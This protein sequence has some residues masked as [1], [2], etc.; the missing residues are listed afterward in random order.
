M[1][2]ARA[3]VLVAAA[4]ALVSGAG[5]ADPRTPPGL[6]GLP[7]PFLGTAL[8]GDGGMTV[9]VDS[10]GSVVD[11]RPGGPASAP[12]IAVSSR[13]QAAGTVPAGASLS[14][15]VGGPGPLE[16]LWRASRVRQ[17]RPR[18]GALSTAAEVGRLTVSITD[19]ARGPLFARLIRVR[20][21]PGRS[22]RAAVGPVPEDGAR[23]L[24]GSTG[25]RDPE[26]PPSVPAGPGPA[27]DARP[28]PP[29]HRHL[30]RG[31]G[32]IAGWLVCGAAPPAPGSG[33]DPRELVGTAAIAA[34]RWLGA[35]RPLG[36]A[37][38]GWARATYRRSLLVLRS[39][40]D[41]RTG[42]FAAGARDGWAYVW[43]RD[44]AAAAIALQRSGHRSLARRI[45]RFLAG[46]DIDAA[47][48][49][50]GGG[51]PVGGR[52][53]Q[54]DA[55]GWIRAAL[56]ATRDRAPARRGA[57]RERADYQ[58]RSGGGGALL[59]N[60]IASGLPA[61]RL[62]ALFAS[63]GE[64]VREAGDPGSGPDSAAAWAVAPF[65]R[66]ALRRPAA[67][68]L[69]A[70][71]ADA[72][73]YGILP[74]ADWPG[75]DPWTA[76]TAWTAWSLAAL[77]ERRAAIALLRRLRRASTPAG[78]LPERVDRRT[79]LPVST[80]PLGWSHAF[81]ALALLRLWPGPG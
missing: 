29:G 49:F 54:G 20:G 73:P 38:P 65:P 6:P 58:E 11:M 13:R 8:L 15:R 79:G 7:A 21:A 68:T 25:G 45:A 80:T 52:S 23:C 9:A 26:Q 66:P 19:A 41:R 81:A 67:R 35:G 27:T 75:R 34:G 78:F 53:A 48:R 1:A 74:S 71:A 14:V 36:P 37:A 4:G 55:A 63:G 64:L 77:G 24:A 70:L 57:W 16:P 62:R 3:A 43:P 22:V 47:A 60:A 44:A 30:W 56:E 40:T 33:G 10:Y 42:A 17:L 61:G 69:A 5:A 72:S 59:G 32:E 46:L 51:A 50:G 18:H 76:P 2:W 39:L 12:A 28:V 31:R